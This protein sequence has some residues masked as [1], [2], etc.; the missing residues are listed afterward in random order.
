MSTTAPPARQAARIGRIAAIVVLVLVPGVGVPQP[1]PGGGDPP[2]SGGG[3]DASLLDVTSVLD[4]NALG[5]V[6]RSAT[7]LDLGG[8]QVALA[9]LLSWVHAFAVE[10]G[11]PHSASDHAARL[12]RAGE[13]S[14]MLRQV[15]GA[16]QNGRGGPVVG[17]N[18][19][20]LAAFDRLAG[21]LDGVVRAPCLPGGPGSV[22]GGLPSGMPGGLSGAPGLAHGVPS[23]LG[24]PPGGGIPGVAPGA[25]MT[26]LPAG[27]GVPAPPGLPSAEVGPGGPGALGAAGPGTPLG[28]PG[29]LMPPAGVAGGPGLP[30]AA[31]PKPGIAGA[32]VVPGG[33]APGVKAVRIPGL[34]G[35]SKAGGA[36]KGL[37]GV[38]TPPVGLPTAGA[39]PPS[40]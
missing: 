8:R 38:A 32:P 20:V 4:A 33:G 28:G 7:R 24:G 14:R 26:G 11:R 23:G 2:P 6:A 1:L 13:L 39:K 25:G 15:R 29:A 5:P 18:L 37:P 10:E 34:A 16:L 12:R 3:L 9:E 31:S 36:P 21:Q 17:R 22:P 40:S 19:A 35:G 30:G 27:G